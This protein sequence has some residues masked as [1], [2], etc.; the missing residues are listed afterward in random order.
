MLPEAA[1]LPAL[2]GAALA[3]PA[4][5]LL[6]AAALEL[7]VI[8]VLAP[9]TVNRRVL[10][11]AGLVGLLV[12]LVMAVMTDPVLLGLPLLLLGAGQAVLPG[13][14]SA[15]ARARG[16]VLGALL[17]A[18]GAALLRSG[19]TGAAPR[20]A[21]MLLAA[22]LA[23]SAGLIPFLQRLDPEEP[24]SAS[25]VA[26][27][28]FLGPPA[29]AAY[30]LRVQAL[31]S[32]D[33]AAVFSAVVAGLGILNL[34]AAIV[35]AWLTQENIRAWRYSF[36]ADWGLALVGFGIAVPDG[37]RAALVVLVSL[38]VVRLP[39]Y[40]FARPVLRRGP[41]PRNA[42]FNLAL[43]GLLAGLA[44]FA[45]FAAR[46][47]LLRAAVA[48]YWPLAVVL[49]IAMLLWL[50]HSFRLAASVGRPSGRSAVGIGLAMAAALAIGIYP[51]PLLAAAGLAP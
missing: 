30:L 33:V 44:P 39:L 1:V 43:A 4:R 35:G 23:V 29:A 49:G 47:L 46:L 18:L 40:F 25:P 17:A 31:L 34:F 9:A 12:L 21:A 20:V 36:L 19:A 51:A 2:P 50:G 10:L 5:V 26:W 28:G 13:T 8:V 27:L 42:G 11:W 45:G 15:A 24:T 37:R 41:P 48:L 14:R 22:A 3:G 16:P 7:A 6:V 32:A 38:L